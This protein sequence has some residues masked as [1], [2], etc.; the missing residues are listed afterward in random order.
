M[1]RNYCNRV[2]FRSMRLALVKLLLLLFFSE[3][4]G[5]GWGGVGWC[6]GGEALFCFKL[7]NKLLNKKTAL[8]KEAT[9]QGVSSMIVG[10][11][12]TFSSEIPLV[13]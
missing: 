9:V 11:K 5:V 12:L 10:M 3:W 4:G 7:K 1:R 2:Y 13:N 6:G 8:I